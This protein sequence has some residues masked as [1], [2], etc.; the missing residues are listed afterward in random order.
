MESTTQTLSGYGAP[1]KNTVGNIG[2]TY[3][4]LNTGIEYACVTICSYTGHKSFTI[5]YVWKKEFNISSGE[6]TEGGITD[7]SKLSNLPKINGVTVKGN[8]TLD[9]LG[10]SKYIEE[11]VLGG[12]S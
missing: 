5:E 1:T 7:Y 9:N 11:L 12:A 4:D 6:P 10:I 2:D 3:T 8:L